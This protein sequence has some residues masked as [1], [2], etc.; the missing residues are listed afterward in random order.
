[1]KLKSIVVSWDFF[2]ATIVTSA[3]AVLLP[4]WVKND[5]AKDLYGVG[6]S[7][8]SIVF[9]VFFAALAIVMASSDDEFV[10]FLEVK[11]DYTR[12]ISSMRFTL[13][14][15]FISLVAALFL[16]SYSSYRLTEKVEN[17]RF[18]W[19]TIFAFLFSYSLGASLGATTDS[20][21]YSGYRSKFLR[22]NQGK[23]Q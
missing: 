18:L 19:L 20:I 1:M 6:I 16:Y 13:T 4:H 14:V 8:L 22:L 23:H 12:L 15:L 2:F 3:C 21:K 5:F 7:V 9:S 17:Q 11:G 10:K